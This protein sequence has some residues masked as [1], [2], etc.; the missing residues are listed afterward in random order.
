MKDV[1]DDCRLGDLKLKSRVI[2][3]GLWESQMGKRGKISED[4]FKRYESIA[5]SGVGLITS[6]LISL[7]PQDKFN[8]LSHNI[9]RPDFVHD[10]RRLNDMVHEYAVP[11]F[12]QLMFVQFNRGI[13][14][15]VG[16]NDL[17]LDDIRKIQVDIIGACKK[18][19]FSGFDGVQL[20]VGNNFFLSKFI[21]PYFNQRSDE[22]GGDTAGRARIL[23]E[24]IRVI[25]DNLNIHINCRIN[26]YD[27]RKG[28]ITSDESIMMCKLLQEYGA[29]SIQITK[30][31]SPL[32]FTNDN[33]NNELIDY[34][35]KLKDEISIPVIV[36]GGFND[37]NQVTK[38]INEKDIDFVS[39]YR[40]FVAQPD[41]LLDW[42][43]GKNIKSRCNSCNN[44][45]RQ[46]TSTC[47]YY[48]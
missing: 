18:I 46:K 15:N 34:Y 33:E 47:K 35:Q 24:I 48:L 10:F 5:G 14:L 39:M 40:P 6:E 44:C 27:G 7:Y 13:D 41:F 25:K 23:L 42:K 37:K 20:N 38:L 36:G 43:R 29:D 4:V 31:L 26:A 16:V 11:I 22:Y 9:F 30:P 12:A 3:T 2:R 32:Y 45:Y 1:F 19:M 28:G 8:N 17:T 21:S